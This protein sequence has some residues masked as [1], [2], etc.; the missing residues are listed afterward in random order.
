M[1]FNKKENKSHN[2]LS[3]LK[4]I[5]YKKNDNK[6]NEILNDLITIPLEFKYS[7]T[8]N[9]SDNKQQ[10]EKL[11]N[12]FKIN[13]I[14]IIKKDNNDIENNDKK[15]N[16]INWQ[17]EKIDISKIT[18]LYNKR[19]LIYTNSSKSINNKIEEINKNDPFLAMKTL[20]DN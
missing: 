15:K 13:N 2:V 7:F 5:S 20:F 8:L 16:E 19:K 1:N 17:I 10:S 6:Q 3:L 12:P 9:S 4:K 11:D 18:I 14:E